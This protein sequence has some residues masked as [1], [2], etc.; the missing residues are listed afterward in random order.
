MKLALTA[1]GQVQT[2]DTAGSF[3][4]T[5]DQYVI[6]A[7]RNIIA[8]CVTNQGEYNLEN[9]LEEQIANSRKVS[10]DGSTTTYDLTSGIDFSKPRMTGEALAKV[11]Y[12]QDVSKWIT[13]DG[14]ELKVNPTSKLEIRIQSEHDKAVEKTIDDFKKD[15]EHEELKTNYS[16]QVE[17]AANYHAGVASYLFLGIGTTLLLQHMQN[18]R[19]KSEYLGQLLSKLMANITVSSLQ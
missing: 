6:P 13:V 16:S 19:L 15:I 17:S 12:E 10:P 18:S 2:S 11:I 5:N 9:M 1:D 7:E 14:D 4:S 3:E 8:A